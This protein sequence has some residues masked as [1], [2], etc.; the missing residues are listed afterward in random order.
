MVSEEMCPVEEAVAYRSPYEIVELHRKHVSRCGEG[1]IDRKAVADRLLRRATETALRYL[2]SSIRT[3]AP[4]IA[5]SCGIMYAELSVL[6]LAFRRE[7]YVL[8]MERQLSFHVP[9]DGYRR[10]V[11]TL[12]E[13]VTSVVTV[14]YKGEVPLREGLTLKSAAQGVCDSLH[15]LCERRGSYL[16]AACCHTQLPVPLY[17]LPVL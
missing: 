13:H 10:P 5:R 12:M 15:G 1:V 4:D 6:M 8:E 11:P 16:L 3:P 2:Q 17:L 7:S 14:A 9:A